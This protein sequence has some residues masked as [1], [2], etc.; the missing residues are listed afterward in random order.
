MSVMWLIY[1]ISF[2]IVLVFGVLALVYSDRE[3]LIIKNAVAEF[4]WFTVSCTIPILNTITAAI[5]I[6]V[7]TNEIMED[8]NPKKW[9]NKPLFPKK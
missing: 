6:G 3:K 5:I 4:F 7:I 8:D 2:L 9:Y 1:W